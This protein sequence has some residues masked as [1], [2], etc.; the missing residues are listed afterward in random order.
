MN[1][2]LKFHFSNTI[3]EIQRKCQEGELFKCNSY[4]QY[5]KIDL[6]FKYQITR[7]ELINACK[8]YMVRP[9]TKREVQTERSVT[10]ESRA[11]FRNI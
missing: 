10:I 7:N 5:Y 4:L 11:L 8:E 6:S 1:K 2:M 9:S 3:G